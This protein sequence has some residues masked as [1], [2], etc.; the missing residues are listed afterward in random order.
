MI[1]VLRL[2]VVAGEPSGDMMAAELVRTLRTLAPGGV[3]LIGVGGE[4]LCGEGLRPLFPMEELS[5][6]GLIEVLPRLRNLR[7]RLR[8]TIQAGHELSPDLILT[9]DS[10]GFN[11]R[12]LAGLRDS[13]LRRVHYVLPQVW[14]W[15]PGRIASL[16]G[17]ADRWLAVLPFEPDFVAGKGI[18]VEFVGHPAVERIRP[19]EGRRS[20]IS[21]HGLGDAG[22][23]L[24]LM[25]GSRRQELGRHL[26]MLG[27][28]SS[29]L[30][31]D[32]PRLRTVLPTLPHL[33][34]EV[35]DAVSAWPLRPFVAA[36]DGDRRAAMMAA[37][38]AITASGTATLELGIAGVP[39]IVAHR[40]HP[41]TA[42]LARRMIRVPHVAL[43][44]LVLGGAVV[45]ELL[46]AD[47]RADLVTATAGGLL[48]NYAAV[49]AQRESFSR[50]PALLQPG[51]REPPS[52]RAARAVLDVAGRV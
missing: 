47:C 45:P 48:R 18:E 22:P 28:V 27:E 36:S 24:L 2:F 4:H 30:R 17:L 35:A 7:R 34:R 40:L 13:G 23:I 10:P 39:M 1:G 38:L 16:R 43:A 8:Q 33:A 5:V 9:V 21:R 3:D 11:L 42:I 50:L 31:H 41:L 25:P 46:Q 32:F 52:L 26:P 14:A 20:F 37:D 12:L 44:N 49:A 6:M 19:G 15:R 29:R 51:G